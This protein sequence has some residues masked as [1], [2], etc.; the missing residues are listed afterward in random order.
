MTQDTA[1]QEKKQYSDSGVKP[2]M[3]SYR[4]LIFQYQDEALHLIFENSHPVYHDELESQVKGLI[5]VRN[6]QLTQ[7][8]SSLDQIYRDWLSNNSIAEYGVYVFYPWAN[9]VVHLLPKEEFI[10]LRTARNRYKITDAEQASLSTKCVGIIGLSVGQSVA[11]TIALERSCGCLKLADF[12]KLE[13]SNLNRIKT[14]V[15]NL[16]L[17]K[18]IIA[19]REISEIDPFLEFEIFSEGITPENINSFLDASPS[20]DLLIEE[21]DDLKVKIEARKAARVR[22]IPVLMDTSDRGMLDVER[23]D[24]E[25][26]RE[27]LH[28]LVPELDKLD[29]DRL[30]PSQRIGVLLKLVGGLNI[31]DRLKASLLELNQSISSWPQL[32]SSVTMGSGVTADVARKILLGE[33][34]PSGRF[35]ADPDQMV[36]ITQPE[37]PQFNPPPPMKKEY[38]EKCMRSMDI[39]PGDIPSE[40]LIHEAVKMAGM[41][42][43]SGN[44]Q[45]WLFYQMKGAVGVFHNPSRAFSFGDHNNFASYQ[46]IGAAIE[47]LSI[48]MLSK[49]FSTDVK[50]LPIGEASAMLALLTFSKTEASDDVFIDLAD[51]ISERITNREITP[52][53]LVA[54]KALHDL[55]QAVSEF[56]EI[57]VK[58]ITEDELLQKQGEVIAECDRLRVFNDWGHNDFFEREMRWT[59][60]EA[61]QK[62]DGIDIR[63]LGIDPQN[64]L[65]IKILR[66]YKVVST[67]SEINGGKAFDE[68]SLSATR[69]ASAMG[70]ITAADL[71]TET[72]LKAG[73]AW[74]KLWLMATKMDLS[75]HPLISPLYLFNRLHNGGDEVLESYAKDKLSSLHPI[76]KSIW[77]LKN[78]QPLFMFRIFYTDKVP[79]PSKRLSLDKIYYSDGHK[80]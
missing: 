9:R 19:A 45:P 17:P 10:E 73:R 65:A 46:S 63:G 64:L 16:G 69:S 38:M 20:V 29:V 76:F 42:P 26:N 31:S 51:F 54:D 18:T 14:G 15:Q 79:V 41:A 59:E 50:Y 21:C 25:N 58:W 33:A 32:S 12:D 55:A 35:Y 52:R 61:E 67:L 48:Y 77:Q 8:Q 13:L 22:A 30:P 53:K 62:R 3:K 7:D 2:D 40:M 37:S 23:F 60:E 11:T 5:K 66:N 57:G 70:L 44:D 39:E 1:Q 47:N 36:P 78:D 74:E 68:I 28:G 43:S 4:P 49:Q 24:L 6:T 27:L 72:L 80:D 71:K 56:D 34:V 75:F